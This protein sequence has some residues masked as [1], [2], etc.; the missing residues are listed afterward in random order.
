MKRNLTTRQKAIH[1]KNKA[2]G[3]ALIIHPL[4][5][6]A[7]HHITIGKDSNGEPVKIVGL[8]YKKARIAADKGNG[9]MVKA[10]AMNILAEQA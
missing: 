8:K 3:P 1:A 6:I 4:R 10:M 7:S 2:M 5:V 9:A